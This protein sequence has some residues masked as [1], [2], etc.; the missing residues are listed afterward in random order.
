M[1]KLIFAFVFACVTVAAVAEKTVPMHNG[2]PI[3][4][5]I[6]KDALLRVQMRQFGGFVNDVRG[7]KGKVVIVNV[8]SAANVAWF[9]EIIKSFDK[10]VKIAVEVAPGSFDLAAP[11]VQGSASV[12]VVDDPKLP[13]SLVAPESKWAMVNVSSLKTDKPAFFEARVKKA[14]TRAMAYLLG[15]ADSQ[16]PLCVTGCVT[17]PE[18]LDQFV[19]TSKLPIDITGKMAKYV[20]GLGITPYKKSTY[21]NAVREGWAPQPTNEFQKA[22]WD[23][24]HTLPTKPIEIKPETK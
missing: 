20:P 4:Q 13:M 21:K 9:D 18:D 7:Q 10:M 1:N 17:K 6:D 23:A 11:K 3:A 16:Y 2:K 8:Q 24:I 12:F 5:K 22:I 15:S 14:T 19:Y